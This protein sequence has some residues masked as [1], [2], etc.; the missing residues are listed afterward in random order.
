MLLM[1]YNLKYL[2]IMELRFDAILCS[3][4]GNENSDASH[5]YMFTRAAGSSLLFYAMRYQVVEA[6]FLTALAKLHGVA[7]MLTGKVTIANPAR[8][9]PFIIFH[10]LSNKTP[11]HVAKRHRHHEAQWLNDHTYKGYWATAT[12]FH[13]LSLYQSC[14][15]QICAHG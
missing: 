15:V 4:F 8:Q 10:V 6:A 5:I 3:K 14:L 9:F 2:L 11:A 7:I 12:T 1:A 13:V